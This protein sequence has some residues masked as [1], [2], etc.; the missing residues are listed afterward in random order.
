MVYYISF[1]IVRQRIPIADLISYVG[2]EMKR[3]GA[4][5]RGP[6]PICKRGDDR[7]LFFNAK[8][9]L[10]Y[11]HGGCKEGGDIIEFVSRVENIPLKEAAACLWRDFH[12]GS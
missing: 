5:W 3:E 2:L 12:L 10:W 8:N 7:A 6:C 9:N 1:G 4:N 11:C